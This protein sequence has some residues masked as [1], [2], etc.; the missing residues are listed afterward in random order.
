MRLSPALMVVQPIL[1][2]PSLRA[3]LSGELSVVTGS[4]RLCGC[5]RGF[6]PEDLSNQLRR[7]LSTLQRPWVRLDDDPMH[8]PLQHVKCDHPNGTR[9]L[10]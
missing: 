6:E 10:R 8:F 3:G 9:L 5:S 1:H 7:L 4:L 2:V